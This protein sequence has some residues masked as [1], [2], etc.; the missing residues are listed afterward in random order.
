MQVQI[1]WARG[2][3]PRPLWVELEHPLAS[4]SERIQR[5]RTDAQGRCIFESVAPGLVQL[6]GESAGTASAQVEAGVLTQVELAL[7][8]GLLVRGVVQDEDGAPVANAELWLFHRGEFARG[9]IVGQ[10]DATGAF[11]LPGVDPSY[12][13]GAMAPGYEPSAEVRLTDLDRGQLNAHGIVL[14]LRS[15]AGS[16]VLRALDEAGNPVPGALVSLTLPPP[17]SP[18]PSAKTRRPQALR[19]AYLTGTDGTLSLPSLPVGLLVLRTTAAGFAPH[20]REL[21]VEDGEATTAVLR[22][23]ACAR[24]EGQV[25]SSAGDPLANILVA[26]FLP[27]EELIPTAR[28]DAEGR[29]KLA[30]LPTGSVVLTARDPGRAWGQTDGTFSLRPGETATW[31]PIMNAGRSVAG[32]IQGN[33]RVQGRDLQARAADSDLPFAFATSDDLGHFQFP[34]CPQGDLE[35]DLFGAVG[36]RGLVVQTLRIGPGENAAHFDLS[37]LPTCTGQILLRLTMSGTVALYASERSASGIRVESPDPAGRIAFDELCPDT[38]DIEIRQPGQPKLYRRNITLAAGEQIDLGTFVQ[39]PLGSLEI[40]VDGE[41]AHLSPTFLSFVAERYPEAGNPTE[42]PAS[43]LAAPRTD[44]VQSVNMQEDASAMALAPGRYLIC[45][46]GN[47][48]MASQRQLVS[49][50]AGSHA[51]VDFETRPGFLVSLEC[52]PKDAPTADARVAAAVADGGGPARVQD[53]DWNAAEG[54]Y[55]MYTQV[56]PGTHTFGFQATDGTVGSAVFQVAAD[57]TAGPGQALVEG[58]GFQ[59]LRIIVP[60]P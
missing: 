48:N 21:R 26:P 17:A 25:L 42:D 14:T 56:G 13:F 28:T 11:A 53:L 29:Y 23:I 39:E 35:I 58:P 1:L 33:G 32:T 10:S 20:S 9:S 3:S 54:T 24:A 50:E 51:R 18:A 31:N 2:A 55:S 30:D 40:L 47:T 7:P 59:I 44:I 60:M 8:D 49:I 16:A 15:A 41:P 27:F 5:A 36:I 57:G 37:E 12:G 6:H 4:P 22:L 52:R 45:A 46:N 34:E 43:A 19:P 38:Y